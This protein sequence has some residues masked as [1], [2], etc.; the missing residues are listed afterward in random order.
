[1][2]VPVNNQKWKLTDTI[3]REPSPILI[4]LSVLV[5]VP[6]DLMRSSVLLTS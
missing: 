1:M 6:V 5:V 4:P 2:L 3:P